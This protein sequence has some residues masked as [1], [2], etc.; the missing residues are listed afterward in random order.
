MPG[1]L[2]RTIQSVPLIVEFGQTQVRHTSDGLNLHWGLFD[3]GECFTVDRL[4]L[5]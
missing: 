3:L 1:M 4:R 2:G 5:V